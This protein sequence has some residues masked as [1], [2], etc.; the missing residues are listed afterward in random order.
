FATFMVVFGAHFSA[1][2]IVM[3]NSWMQT[4][5]G[6]TIAETPAPARAVMTDI[7]QVIFTP[8]FLPR[9]FHV[10]FASWTAGAALMM[11]VSAWYILKKRHMDLAMSN[12]KVAL[13]GFI[14]FA[15][16]NFFAA[17]PQM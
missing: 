1:L 12:M 7:W 15:C 11:S 14:L 5:Q 16:V 9:L 6:F 3:A 13:S 17:G 4:P 8:S 2:W 10:F